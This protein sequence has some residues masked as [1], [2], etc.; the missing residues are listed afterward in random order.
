MP[1]QFVAVMGAQ[2][3]AALQDLLTVF[4]DNAGYAEVTRINVMSVDSSLATAQMIEVECALL[5]SA[6][7]GSGGSAVTP[8][9]L[10]PGDS[11]PGCSARR[12]DTTPASG[13]EQIVWSGGC[14]LYQGLDYVFT[15]PIPVN[16]IGST[17]AF[18]LRL[19]NN[20]VGTIT[21]TAAVYFEE[22]GLVG[23]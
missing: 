17:T 9:Q 11:A 12:N 16:S 2:S 5:T 1:R 19:V 23:S 14:Y 6:A 10:D 7:V 21:L 18:V 20:P 13:T 8:D 4:L 22:R 15:S 3:V